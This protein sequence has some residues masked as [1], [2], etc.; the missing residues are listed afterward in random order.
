MFL[1]LMIDGEFKMVAELDIENLTHGQ[2]TRKICSLLKV[3]FN[4]GSWRY[5]FFNSGKKFFDVTGVT[6]SK[7]NNLVNGSEDY[8]FDYFEG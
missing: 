6:K 8:A 1:D 2:R 3:P 4:K 7:H 5:N